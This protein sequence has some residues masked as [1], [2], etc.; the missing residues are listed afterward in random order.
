MAIARNAKTEGPTR[1]SVDQDVK[2]A[3][4]STSQ[5]RGVVDTISPCHLKE[6]VHISELLH[7]LMKRV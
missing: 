4:Y 5:N 1:I 3:I 2:V 7:Y 6:T